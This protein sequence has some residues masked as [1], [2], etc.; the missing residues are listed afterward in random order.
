M[1]TIPGNNDCKCFVLFSSLLFCIS[2]CVYTLTHRYIHVIDNLLWKSLYPSM[3]ISFGEI[4][5]TGIISSQL[6]ISFLFVTRM[7]SSS[8]FVQDFLVLTLKVLRPM[9]N[10]HSRLPCLSD[11]HHPE[12]KCKA[13][14]H[15]LI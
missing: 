13:D 9:A 15:S 14:S 3:T 4:P 1:I 8:Q 6:V 12:G 5:R 10:W 2:E 11:L 7:T